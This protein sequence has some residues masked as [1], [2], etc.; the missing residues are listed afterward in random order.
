MV[1]RSVFCTTYST[2]S[3]IDIANAPSS[4]RSFLSRNST[5]G[6]VQDIDCSVS[7]FRGMHHLVQDINCDW[8]VNNIL[9]FS[10]DPLLQFWGEAAKNRHIV[11][12]VPGNYIFMICRFN[13]FYYL[14]N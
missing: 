12:V 3:C 14:V 9:L 4:Y 1:L 8:K 5:N 11:K 10:K 7:L 6:E 13:C 2:F